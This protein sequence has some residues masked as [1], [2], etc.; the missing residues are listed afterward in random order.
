MFVR[1]VCSHGSMEIGEIL[2]LV[3]Q[4]S[5]CRSGVTEPL[6]HNGFSLDS[7]DYKNKWSRHRSFLY[8]FD[9]SPGT[10]VLKLRIEI[11]NQK[12]HDWFTKDLKILSPGV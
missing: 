9:R 10:Y 7:D 8:G 3:G 5:G 4:G 1:I 6:C 12:R 11:P 2:D